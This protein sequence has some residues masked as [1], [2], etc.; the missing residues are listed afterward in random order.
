MWDIMLYLYDIN[1]QDSIVS[2]LNSC[3]ICLYLFAEIASIPVIDAMLRFA[4]SKNPRLKNLA[5]IFLEVSYFSGF[6]DIC[7]SDV[8]G[9]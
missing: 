2:K 8:Q 3:I 1:F 6:I 7:T 9:L 5:V 4:D